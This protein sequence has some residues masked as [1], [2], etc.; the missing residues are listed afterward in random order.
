MAGEQG[1]SRGLPASSRPLLALAYD[2]IK[3]PRDLAEALHLAAGF[4]AELHLLGRSLDPL[5][6]KVL[7]KLRSWRP[8]LE[9][10]LRFHSP[11]RFEGVEP[12]A[13]KMR[14]AGRGVVATAA[15][16]GAAPALPRGGAALAVLIGEETHGLSARELRACDEVWTF[17]LGP[18]GRFYT[19]GQTTALLLGLFSTAER[20]ST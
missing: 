4:G 3:D 17:P 5:H 11:A 16:G 15:S 12:W 7:T 20:A 9:A 2:T 1:P 19:I 14:E 8:E 13:R 6:P 18:G 10:T